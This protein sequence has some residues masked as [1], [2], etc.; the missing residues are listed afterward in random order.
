MARYVTTNLRFSQETYRELQDQ[1]RRR[2]A[3]VAALV[4]EAVG[5]YLGRADGS[6]HVPFGEDP[7]DALVGC[8]ERS[9]GDESINHD[10]YLHGWAKE[11]E[12][13]GAGGRASSW[14]LVASSRAAATSCCSPIPTS[15]AARS[16]AWLA[17]A[18]SA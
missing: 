10:H 5:R 9:G 16:T 15:C 3:T 11:V 12:G 17:S 2:R 6:G 8:V 7:A 4:R 18:T 14:S 13:E 1:A